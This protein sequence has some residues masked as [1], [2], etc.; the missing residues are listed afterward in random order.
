MFLLLPLLLA[1]YTINYGTI[2]LLRLLL[3]CSLLLL[4]LPL[5]LLNSTTTTTTA[6]TSTVLVRP[7][8]YTAQPVLLCVPGEGKGGHGFLRQPFLLRQKQNMLRTYLSAVLWSVVFSQ[9]SNRYTVFCPL[10]LSTTRA[11]QISSPTSTVSPTSP[12][13]MFSCISGM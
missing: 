7:I 3:L 4:L 11:P 6:T 9:S 8:Y 12:R 1:T 10:D 5:V 2:L 13:T